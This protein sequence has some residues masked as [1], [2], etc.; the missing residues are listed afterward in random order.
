MSV[1]ILALTGLVLT[2]GYAITCLIW[3]YGNCRRC[4]GSGKLHSPFGDRHYRHCPRCKHTGTRLRIG[5]RLWS[6][7]RDL[8]NDI[9]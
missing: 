7:W 3:P 6:H 1:P 8:R 2:V 4:H 5:R 9:R